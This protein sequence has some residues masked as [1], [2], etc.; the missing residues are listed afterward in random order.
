MVSYINKKLIGA[1]AVDISLTLVGGIGL[2]KVSKT[3]ARSNETI[4]EKSGQK[5]AVVF[6]IQVGDSGKTTLK[7]PFNETGG[8]LLVKEVGSAKYIL[9]SELPKDEEE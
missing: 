1:A 9:N 5:E 6:E 2:V 8:H 4:S 3:L 7:I